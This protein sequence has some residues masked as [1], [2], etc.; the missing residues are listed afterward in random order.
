MNQ[1]ANSILNNVDVKQS[2]QKL[3]DVAAKD[4]WEHIIFKTQQV[5]LEK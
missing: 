5:P 1:L 4:S 2:L 3:Q